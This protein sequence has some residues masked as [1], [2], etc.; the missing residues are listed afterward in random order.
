MP[1]EPFQRIQLWVTPMQNSLLKKGKQKIVPLEIL[2]G[3]ER[4]SSPNYRHLIN[5]RIQRM[6][7][8]AYSSNLEASLTSCA[9]KYFGTYLGYYCILLLKVQQKV[10]S[11]DTKHFII[12]DRF[13]STKSSLK[14]IEN[15]LQTR[16]KTTQNG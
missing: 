10:N 6:E 2:K 3:S 9:P 14:I 1:Q 5:K 8:Q 4:V 12:A 11:T 13:L 15:Y 7:S 16:K